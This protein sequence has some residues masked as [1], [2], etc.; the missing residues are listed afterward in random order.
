MLLLP[1]DSFVMW[2]DLVFLE[3]S[4]INKAPLLCGTDQGSLDVYWSVQYLIFVE[5]S[6]ISKC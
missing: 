6:T 5:C 1:S 2:K 4:D 3:G